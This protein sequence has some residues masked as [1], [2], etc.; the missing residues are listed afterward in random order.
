M[1][2][3]RSQTKVID[4]SDLDF[5]RLDELIL[6]TP[7]QLGDDAAARVLRPDRL[8][9]DV[10]LTNISPV[11][12]AFILRNASGVELG[13]SLQ[14]ILNVGESESEVHVIV[15]GVAP[16][17]DS[18]LQITARIVQ[19]RLERNEGEERRGSKRWACDEK[20]FPTAIASNPA[21]FNDYLYFSIRDLSRSG[22]RAVT[23]LRNKFIARGMRLDCLVSFP[24]VSQVNLTLEIRNIAVTSEQ[25]KDLLSIGFEFVDPDT[26]ILST[27]AQYLI[28]FGNAASLEEM[29]AADLVPTSVSQAVEYSFARDAEELQEVFQLRTKAYAE[30]GKVSSEDLLVDEYDAKSRI[31]IGKFKGQIVASARIFFPEQGEALEHE[32]YVQLPEECARRDEVVEI[33]RICTDPEFRRSDLLISLFHFIAVTCAQAKRHRVVGCATP[34]L[35]PLYTRIGFRDT[36]ITY[37]H[38]LLGNKEHRVIIANTKACILG[39]GINPIVWNI[40]WKDIA[41]YLINNDF[42]AKDALSELRLLAYK[43]LGP[44]AILAKRRTTKPRSA[45]TPP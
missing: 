39:A 43:A 26:V 3:I 45:K 44:L 33:M 25:G 30:A 15:V 12:V 14:L 41:R 9:A 2:P 8:A 22:A 21:R 5:S 27:V 4:I 17:P 31:V 36:E 32:Q 37:R 23:S 28:Q 6:P 42:L 16:A 38:P 13:D 20:F 11:G 34:E 40:L 29:R 18:A 7:V 24:M 35:V 1:T 19:P 10:R